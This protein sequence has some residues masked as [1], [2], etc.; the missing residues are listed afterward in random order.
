[1]GLRSRIHTAKD[2][3]TYDKKAVAVIGRYQAI[4]MPA[5]GTKGNTRASDAIRDYAVVV[6]RDGTQVYLESYNTSEAKRSPEERKRFDGKQVIVTGTI[7]R[8]MPSWGQAPLAP[9]IV[10]IRSIGLAR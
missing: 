2:I 7:H 6:L 4:P 3:H 10:G 9:A 1:L 5:K 8:R